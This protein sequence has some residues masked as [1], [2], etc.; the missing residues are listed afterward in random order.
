MRIEE[1]IAYQWENIRSEKQYF[2]LDLIKDKLE[3]IFKRHGAIYVPAPLLFPQS[4]DF[5]KIGSQV[6]LMTNSGNIVHLPYDLRISFARYVASKALIRLRRYV[7]ERVYRQKKVHGLY[8][9]EQYECAF[10]L[11]TPKS[12]GKSKCKIVVV[13]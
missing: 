9:K 1:D 13:L 10:D 7:I 4:K 11:V 8:P 2:L 5:R 12:T 6:Q 3:V